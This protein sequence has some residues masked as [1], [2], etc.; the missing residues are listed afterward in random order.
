MTHPG[1]APERSSSAIEQDYLEDNIATVAFHIGRPGARLSVTNDVS[2]L[3][4][5]A[6]EILKEVSL[7][8]TAHAQ[9]MPSSPWSPIRCLDLKKDDTYLVRVEDS[10]GRSWIDKAYY[11]DDDR[12]WLRQDN[13]N[14]QSQGDCIR[15]MASCG[16]HNRQ[17]HQRLRCERRRSF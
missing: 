7:R 1:Q 11:A 5:D 15:A 9:L 14:P 8:L 2:G 12:V 10:D 16:R 17:S 6:G 3:I 4:V 13:R